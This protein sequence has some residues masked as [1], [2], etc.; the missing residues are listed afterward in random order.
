[1]RRKGQVRVNEKV[2]ELRRAIYHFLDEAIVCKPEDERSKIEDLVV[3][4]GR[5]FGDALLRYSNGTLATRRVD[6]NVTSLMKNY[7]ELNR[8]DLDIQAIEMVRRP[9]GER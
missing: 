1:V 2:Q 9:P 5:A 6:D 8:R 4:T 7:N 3:E